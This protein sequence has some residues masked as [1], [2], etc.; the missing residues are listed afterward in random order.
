M[1]LKHKNRTIIRPETL[2]SLPE[3]EPT[4][5]PPPPFNEDDFWDR[6]PDFTATDEELRAVI[7]EFMFAGDKYCFMLED[8]IGWFAVL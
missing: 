2:P 5:P 7:R 8:R 3:H 1:Y 6:R 4:L